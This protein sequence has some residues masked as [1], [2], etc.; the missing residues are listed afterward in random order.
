MQYIPTYDVMINILLMHFCIKGVYCFLI[1]VFDVPGNSRRARQ[2][3][4]FDNVSDIVINNAVENDIV[5]ISA[6]ENTTNTWQTNLD[7]QVIC[8]RLNFYL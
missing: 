8:I 2:F 1:T 4:L 7:E 3:V 6:S 5:V